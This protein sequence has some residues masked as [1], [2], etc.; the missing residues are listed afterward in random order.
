LLST[1][2]LNRTF[3]DPFLDCEKTEE[4]YFEELE[5]GGDIYCE[6]PDLSGGIEGIDHS[7]VYGGDDED[8]K[9]ES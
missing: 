2:V 6:E 4:E 5:N 1:L 9:V 8:T 7:I 3:L